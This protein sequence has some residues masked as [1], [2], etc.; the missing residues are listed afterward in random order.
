MRPK[1][2]L[3]DLDKFHERAWNPIGSPLMQRIL[4]SGLVEVTTFPPAVSCPELVLEYMN[5]YDPIERC[6]RGVDGEVLLRVSQEVVVV[7]MKI[8]EKDQY[9]D[10]MVCKS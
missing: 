2:P 6:M 1:F 8:L 7:I 3:V 10:W 5:I 9:E 4:D